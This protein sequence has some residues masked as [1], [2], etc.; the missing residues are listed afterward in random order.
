MQAGDDQQAVEHAKH[1]RA[2]AAAFHQQ[3]AEAVDAGWIG[4]QIRPKIT[5]RPTAEKP[6]TIGTNRRPPKTPGTPAT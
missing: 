4:G 3:H 1:E 5:P 6:V 2:Q